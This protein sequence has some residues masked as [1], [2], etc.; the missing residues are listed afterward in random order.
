MKPSS[1]TPAER[2]RRIAVAR[3]PSTPEVVVSIAAGCV[4]LAVHDGNASVVVDMPADTAL[5]VAASMRRKA[6]SIHEVLGTKPK[7][8]RAEKR[9]AKRKGAKR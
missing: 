5:D 7:Q 6:M 4:V 3:V 2:R 1:E 8:A 9:A